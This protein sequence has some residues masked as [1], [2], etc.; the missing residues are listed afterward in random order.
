MSR[1]ELHS[2]AIGMFD[3]G[4]GGLTVMRQLVRVLPRE[5][6][7]YFGDTA[8]LPYGEKSRETIIRYSIENAIFLLERNIKLLVVAC[9]TASAHAIEKLQQIF[10]IPIIGVIEPGAEKAV[11]VSRNGQIAVLGTKGTIHSQMYQKAISSRRPDA[12]VLPI[13]C[14]L[15][16]PLIEEQFIDHQATRL[17]V[18]EYLKPLQEHPVDTILFGCTHYPLLR[19]LIQEEIGPDVA[20]VDSATTCAEKVEK[21]LQTHQLGSIS[22]TLPVHQY[23]VSDDAPKFQKLGQAFLGAPIQNVELMT[24]Q[25]F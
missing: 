9:N 21:V 22:T 13:A 23:F 4:I 14:P 17:I 6:I 3:S 16:A 19:E 24:A 1:Q 7:V 10:N 11:Q 2:C 18:K 8:R 5:R 12:V 15:F 20:I 25:F